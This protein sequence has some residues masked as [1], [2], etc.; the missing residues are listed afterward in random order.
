MDTRHGGQLE[1]CYCSLLDVGACGSG[2]MLAA[3][4]NHVGV[5]S[6]NSSGIMFRLLTSSCSLRVTRFGLFRALLVFRLA[7]VLGLDRGDALVFVF[8]W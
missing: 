2:F 4:H 5:A 1:A 8:P 6:V 3:V 7:L